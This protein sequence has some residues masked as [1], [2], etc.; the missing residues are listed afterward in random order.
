M[1][2]TNQHQDQT[3]DCQ[4]SQVDVS[5]QDGYQHQSIDPITPIYTGNSLQNYYYSTSTP[6][7][8]TPSYAEG[9]FHKDDITKPKLLQHEIAQSSSSFRDSGY[10]SQSQDLLSSKL[11][12]SRIGQQTLDFI[13]E[14]AR[15]NCFFLC[16]KIMVFLDEKDLVR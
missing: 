2:N 5:D 13:T 14:L 1:D 4:H 9:S 6:E 11:I 15:I 3:T 10:N 12:G 8:Y 16:N 7:C